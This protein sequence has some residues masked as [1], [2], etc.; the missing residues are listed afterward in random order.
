MNKYNI[1]YADPPWFYN[2]RKKIRKDG[3]NPTFGV[4]A[5]NHYDL[6]K[7]SDIIQ[8]PVNNIADDNCA[9]LLWATPPCLAEALQVMKE[10]GFNYKTFAFS[11]VKT[12]KNN[13]NP[14]FGVGYYTKSNVE[15]CLLGIKGKMKP[16]SNKISQ[17][18]MEPHPVNEN[19]KK[20]H[21]RKP[22][23]VRAKIVEL[24]GNLPRVELFSRQKTEGWHVWGDQ[25]ESDLI[26]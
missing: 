23:S 25:I 2:D 10:W 18:I 15:I 4:G 12:N 24:F 21:S 14:F 6:M 11:W 3:K 26:L 1:I 8:L 19:G 9:L 22:D 20:I 7:L 16:I 5:G 17:I 13:S